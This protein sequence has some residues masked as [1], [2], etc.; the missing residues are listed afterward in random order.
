MDRNGR[1]LVTPPLRD[2]AQLSKNAVLLGQGN[3]LE[4]WDETLWT[5]RREQWLDEESEAQL[6]EELKSLSL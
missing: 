2:Y 5:E 1:L 6:P 3:K 4:L